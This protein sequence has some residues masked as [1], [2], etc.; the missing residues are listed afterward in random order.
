MAQD[1]TYSP[2]DSPA[3]SQA[4]DESNGY[5][6]SSTDADASAEYPIQ[7]WVASDVASHFLDRSAL[8]YLGPAS[9]VEP[10]YSR[11]SRVNSSSSGSAGSDDAMDA[12]LNSFGDEPWTPITPTTPHAAQGQAG[13]FQGPMAAIGYAGSTP[14]SPTIPEWAAHATSAYPDQWASPSGS[15]RE[16]SPSC[17][18]AF[19][20]NRTSSSTKTQKIVLTVKGDDGARPSNH[21]TRATSIPGDKNT[22]QSPLAA[23]PLLRT[24]ARRVRTP[25]AAQKPGESLERQRARTS[26]NIVEKEYRVRLHSGFEHLLDVLPSGDIG[27]SGDGIKD[28]RLSKAEVLDKASSYIM[29]LEDKLAKEK[30]E[31]AELK[32]G[33]AKPNL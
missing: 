16:D 12:S 11:S 20:S 3:E 26:H 29:L 8:G 15:Q 33:I 32:A 18:R 30:R 22:E 17:E 27:G 13:Y 24:A 4:Y 9:A 25:R 7:P 19:S 10:S 14:V 6:L 31:N 28:K 23:T 21:V 5:S 1:E 2:Q